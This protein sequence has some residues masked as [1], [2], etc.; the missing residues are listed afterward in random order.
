MKKTFPLDQSENCVCLSTRIVYDQ[1]QYWCNATTRQLTMSFICPRRYFTYDKREKQPLI[2]MVCGGG[3][4]KEDVNV[5]VPELSFFAKHGYS[6]A[7][8]DYSVL[9]FTEWPEPIEDVKSAIRFLRAHAEE[10][11]IDP[12][13]IAIM[14]ESAGGYLAALAAVTG[15]TK[16]FDK[17]QNLEYSSAVKCAVP[18][19]PV[20]NPKMMPDPR[21]YDP[22]TDTYKLPVTG[23]GKRTL[24]MPDVASYV[25]ENT[26]PI[27]MVHGTADELVNISQSEYLYDKLVEKGVEANLLIVEGAGH[28]DAG[29][30]N[31]AVKQ[32]MLAFL[33]RHMKN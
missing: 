9:P 1:K 10:F 7:C 18:W 33:D 16:E 14:G 20:I 17:G 11:M 26:P 13:R 30:V 28:A 4:E 22:V 19:Y 2:V 21:I 6:V 32:E 24:A 31:S 15:E 25:T 3:F 23:P 8:V 5:W 29:I 27:C 12:D